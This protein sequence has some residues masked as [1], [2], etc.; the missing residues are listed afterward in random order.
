MIY[1]KV[2]DST[3]VYT[4]DYNMTPDRHLGA[5]QIERLQLDLLITEYVTFTCNARLLILLFDELFRNYKIFLTCIMVLLIWLCILTAYSFNHNYYFQN[6]CKLF[7]A[8][9][10]DP[11]MTFFLIVHLADHHRES[12]VIR[13]CLLNTKEITLY[14]LMPMSLYCAYVL[15]WNFC[16]IHSLIHPNFSV[17]WTWVL[18][19]RTR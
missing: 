19:W 11:S 15:L 3:M 8:A 1:A 4:G 10:V 7:W 14:L 18:R 17:Y 13:S 9:F 12:S 6:L 2:G 16:H 5:A